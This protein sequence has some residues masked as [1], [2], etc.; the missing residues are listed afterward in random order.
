MT[1]QKQAIWPFVLM[2]IFYAL[3][4]VGSSVIL[5]FGLAFGSEAYRDRGIPFEELAMMSGPFVV[6]LVLL[7]ATVFLW[8]ARKYLATYII[9]GACFVMFFFAF[10]GGLG[11]IL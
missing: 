8:N 5:F 10:F 1:E 4:L 3:M 7:V 2:L 6:S 11:L 9:F